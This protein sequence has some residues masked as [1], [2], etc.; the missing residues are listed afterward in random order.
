MTK[1]PC[2]MHCRTR[3]AITSKGS[4]SADSTLQQPVSRQMRCTH[5]LT[6]LFLKGVD[7]ALSDGQWRM[8]R[9]L[10]YQPTTSWYGHQPK[11]DFGTTLASISSSAFCHTSGKSTGDICSATAQIFSAQRK[12]RSY[13][14]GFRRPNNH[15]RLPNSTGER[16]FKRNCRSR[17]SRS[18]GYFAADLVVSAA[19]DTT[20]GYEDQNKTPSKQYALLVLASPSLLLNEECRAAYRYLTKSHS[21]HFSP[22]KVTTFAGR[23]IASPGKP[24]KDYRRCVLPCCSI[25]SALPSLLRLPQYH[26]CLSLHCHSGTSPG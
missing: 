16:D 2:P 18:D 3:M 20:A 6:A 26:F 21:F 25:S 8:A 10:P 17:P 5:C 11:H 7:A 4:S 13:T 22:N 12:R 24:P 15:N 19:A 9:S 1:L 14:S 23:R